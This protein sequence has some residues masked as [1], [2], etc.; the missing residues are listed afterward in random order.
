MRDVKPDRSSASAE[1]QVARVLEPGERLLWSGKAN[2]DAVRA[3]AQR[4]ALPLPLV[5]LLFNG[6]FLW[7]FSRTL[8]IHGVGDLIDTLSGHRDLALIVIAAIL[9]PLIGS[10]LGRRFGFDRTS[11][12]C[13]YLARFSYGLTDRRVL[14][15]KDEKIQYAL[16]PKDIG[17]IYR[18]SRAPG[19]G[20]LI[21]R[22]IQNSDY[23]P[24]GREIRID[25]I[26]DAEG[27]RRRIEDWIRGHQ[28]QAAREVDQFVHAGAH[29]QAGNIA[30]GIQRIINHRWGLQIDVPDNWETKV[31]QRRK[32]YGTIF[33]DSENW[34]SPEALDDWNVLHTEGPVTVSV[35]LHVDETRP[36]LGYEKL[37]NST[38]QK[39]FGGEL[40]ESRESLS[41]GGFQGFS[42]TRRLVQSRQDVKTG[43]K[44]RAIMRKLIAYHDGRRQ[45]AMISTW[46]AEDARLEKAVAAIVTSLIVSGLPG[47]G[48]EQMAS[49]TGFKWSVTGFIRGM[50][51]LLR[52]AF[53]LFALGIGV[54]GAYGQTYIIKRADQGVE[55]LRKALEKGI[56]TVS[57]DAVDRQYD[58]QL[59]YMQGTLQPRLV[60]DPVTGLTL[61]AAG[62]HRTV[63][64]Y[65]WH[66]K[67]RLSSRGSESYSFDQVWSE[68]L[69]DSDQFHEPLFGKSQNHDNPKALPYETNVW[70][71]P[72]DMRIGAWRV[73]VHYYVQWIAQEKPVPDEVLAAAVSP[74]DWYASDGYLQKRE[75]GWS[76]VRFRYDYTPVPEGGY[77]IIGVAHDGALDLED[78][79]VDLPLIASGAVDAATLISRA[80][81]AERPRQRHWI[82]WVFIG[83]LL[84][85]RP[86]AMPFGFLR[87]LTEAP[88]RR[89]IPISMAVAALI[90][91]AV[92]LF[93]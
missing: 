58:G 84:A 33:F 93:V 70:F 59:V 12:R 81:A 60:T 1:Q 43:A 28:E 44:G 57:P 64:L 17:S 20:D 35:E 77:S 7:M 16:S 67:S 75:Y 14:I 68:R 69:I 10:V 52:V 21:F 26:R 6:L 92:G 29:S 90:T 41:L 18:N 31:R 72:E 39:M 38:L 86:L 85:L 89:R 74:E 79:L 3:R 55:T 62:L 66:E 61:T 8:G 34:Q 27:V 54:W 19:Y 42:V 25:A 4:F 36:T 37:L 80:A 40:V 48:R 13:R 46:P 73:P 22:L 56:P 83:V 63:E 82:A 78:T 51:R 11:Q 24:G 65:Q 15:L 2:S 49:V 87:G 71:E 50:L 5:L 23:N 88:A 30:E 45:I 53:G 91:A 47:E 76:N 32:P 9:I